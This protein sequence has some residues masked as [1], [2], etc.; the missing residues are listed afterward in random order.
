MVSLPG[1]P[2]VD[3]AVELV[4]VLV[5]VGQRGDA[6]LVGHVPR[7]R[8]GV[9]GAGDDRRDHADLALVDEL[10]EGGLLRRP[11]VAEVGVEIARAECRGCVLDR[12]VALD[13][14]VVPQLLEDLHGDLVLDLEVDPGLLGEHDRVGTAARGVVGETARVGLRVGGA[15]GDDDEGRHGGDGLGEASE[16]S[17]GSVGHLLLL[18]TDGRGR[19]IH[20]SFIYERHSRHT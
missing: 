19:C 17:A 13:R 18:V 7:N 8:R 2:A 14:G 6:E 5:E 10:T 16:R 9:L 4:G 11:P 1:D 15:T 20:D 12:E 3:L